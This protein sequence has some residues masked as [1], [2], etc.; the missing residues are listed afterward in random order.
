MVVAAARF[1]DRVTIRRL[2][3]VPDG[4]GGFDRGWVTLFDTIPAEVV[5][6]GGRESVLASTLTGVS[7][8]RITVR[9]RDGIKPA[10]QVVWKGRE[11]NIL[12]VEADFRDPVAAVVMF[13]DTTA[14]LGAA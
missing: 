4:K 2:Q 10:D 1:R 6:Q 13:C 12:N 8:F 11:L 3:D 9:K 7:V 14:P 5:S